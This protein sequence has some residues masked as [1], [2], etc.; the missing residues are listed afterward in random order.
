MNSLQALSPRH[1]RYQ[2]ANEANER[3]DGLKLN[4]KSFDFLEE[5]PSA[6]PG[7]F[8]VQLHHLGKFYVAV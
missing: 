7:S 1:E 3:R 4:E 5:R 8:T 6:R 2:T